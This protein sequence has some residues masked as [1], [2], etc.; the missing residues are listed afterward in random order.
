M[1]WTVFNC[2]DTD[3]ST[4]C[5][6]K[7]C[8]LCPF[9]WVPYSSPVE[10][11]QRVVLPPFPQ[12][13]GMQPRG[14]GDAGGFGS[15][16]F[17][18]CMSRLASCLSQPSHPRGTGA[19]HHPPGESQ[20]RVSSS[21]WSRLAFQ[22]QAITKCPSGT[23]WAF[24]TQGNKSAWLFWE[25]VKVE[26]NGGRWVTK[27]LCRF[28]LLKSPK[29]LG[30]MWVSE[31]VLEV[32]TGEMLRGTVWLLTPLL[33]GTLVPFSVCCSPTGM[34]SWDC[35]GVMLLR[36]HLIPPASSAHGSPGSPHM[37]ESWSG[38]WCSCQCCQ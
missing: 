8:P 14:R 37:Q 4:A 27:L 26:V 16:C 23:E 21:I 31:G 2:T 5:V 36:C 9:P 1:W 12:L 28:P 25:R 33:R 15:M 11:V 38:L 13:F 24:E 34:R 17:A 32:R 18:L 30:S 19:L 29:T 35:S 7:S 6:L 3:T 10:E 20:P 22:F